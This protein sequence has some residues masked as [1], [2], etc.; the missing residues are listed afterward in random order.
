MKYLKGDDWQGSGIEDTALNPSP[1]QT[2]PSCN[3]QNYSVIPNGLKLKPQINKIK[4]IQSQLSLSFYSFQDKTQK[5]I[6]PDGKIRIL[7]VKNSRIVEGNQYKNKKG[8]K[9]NN[10]NKKTKEK[11][12]RLNI[13]RFLGVQRL[14][15]FL[16]SGLFS[17]WQKIV[18]KL[19]LFFI[20]FFPLC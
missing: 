17:N 11:Y 4:N 14:N 20:S 1:R 3:S 10:N 16:S 15:A 18:E 19:F 9:K 7:G 2:P 8:K 12:A 6:N 5:M 13:R